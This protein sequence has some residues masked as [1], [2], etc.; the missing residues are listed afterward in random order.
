[1][2]RVQTELPEDSEVKLAMTV[3]GE[4][5][6]FRRFVEAD[7]ALANGDAAAAER[8]LDGM[9]EN[10]VAKEEVLVRMLGI[11]KSLG[12]SAQGKRRIESLLARHPG[13]PI[14]LDA[15]F[16]LSR[17]QRDPRV[18]IDELRATAAAS[19]SGLPSR[20]LE[21]LLTE[22]DV[23]RSELVDLIRVRLAR[24]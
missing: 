2:R 20:R 24:R 6:A 10:S 17:G 15:R 13:D 9:L 16:A 12:R 7:Q 1:M 18:F 5:P 11:L 22:S 14:L 4:D 8:L 21:L 19:M 3:I 23:D